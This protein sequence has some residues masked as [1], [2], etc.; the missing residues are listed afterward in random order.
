ML[1]EASIDD[2]LYQSDSL[3]EKGQLLQT[4]VLPEMKEPAC[5]FYSWDIK[6]AEP[7]I[8]EPGDT[9]L[10]AECGLRILWALTPTPRTK[11]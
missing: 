2:Y 10:M 3:P 5:T 4:C 11:N 7:V 8:L 9:A 6:D 1:K